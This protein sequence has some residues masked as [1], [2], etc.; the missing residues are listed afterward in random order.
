MFLLRA[1]VWKVLRRSAEQLDW[2]N[3]EEVKTMMDWG[4]WIEATEERESC[5]FSTGR[6]EQGWNFRLRI[7]ILEYTVLPEGYTVHS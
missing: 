3:P 6:G 4:C 1:G 5:F 7:E 2:A